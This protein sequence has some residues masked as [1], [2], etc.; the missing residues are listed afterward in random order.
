MHHA[1]IVARMAPD[2]A[3][4]I[5]NVFEASDRGE[6]PDLVGVTR[7]SLFQFGDVYLHLIEADRPPGPAVAKV[8]DHP[9]FRDISDKLSAYVSAYDP[10][11]WRSPKDAMAREFYRWERAAKG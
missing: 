10:K 9:A 11:T 2:S 4:D 5:A 7:R 3:H 8:A 6:L 1:L